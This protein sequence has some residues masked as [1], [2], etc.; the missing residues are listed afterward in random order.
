VEETGMSAFH[1]SDLEK[2][3]EKYGIP[4]DEIISFAAN[5][6]PLGVSQGMIDAMKDQI[7]CIE[8][9]PERD[10]SRLR[11]AVG[12]YCKADPEHII[13]GNG[14]SELIGDVIK[15]RAGKTALI[16]APAYSE[17]E[18]YVKLAGGTPVY[19]DLKEEEDFRFD[20]K[21]LYERT[22]DDTL[23]DGLLII[24]NPLNPT[25]TA[26]RAEDMRD[27]LKLCEKKNITCVVDETY[28]DFADEEYDMSY[29]TKE[30][31][32]LFVIR[33]MSKFFS[34]PGLR[35]G[36]AITSDDRLKSAVEEIKDPW[37]VSSFSEAAARYML[38]DKE[39]IKEVGEYIGRERKRVCKMLDELKAKGLKYYEPKANFVLVKLPDNGMKADG[40]FE[41]AIRQGMMIRDC[42]T[43]RGLDESYI[44]FCFMRKEDDDRL[45]GLITETVD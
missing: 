5:V 3:E 28:V 16:V 30:Y 39:Y 18:R 44:R 2:I 37:S 7:R 19:H 9:Y 32:S 23:S 43:F 38:T 11:K 25:S 8:R 26:V 31:R 15:Y 27:I 4:R 12:T 24:C 45:I 10:Y 6:S 14:S 36:Y 40:L 34:A 22:D 42:S 29:L 17:Y 13:V 20:L 21:A 1:G 33:S 41:L 35:L